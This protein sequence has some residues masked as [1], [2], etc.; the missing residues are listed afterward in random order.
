MCE[1]AW[2]FSGRTVEYS[3]REL[4]N[5]MQNDVAKRCSDSTCSNSL[6]R[7]HVCLVAKQPCDMVAIL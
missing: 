4:A 1:R 2:C 7:S 6:F 3:E 5:C